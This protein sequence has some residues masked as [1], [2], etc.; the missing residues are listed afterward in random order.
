VVALVVGA[1]I[2]GTVVDV[3]SGGGPTGRP[4]S[5]PSAFKGGRGRDGSSCDEPSWDAMA[6]A[7]TATTVTTGA[8]TATHFLPISGPRSTRFGVQAVQASSTSTRTARRLRSTPV[9]PT[10]RGDQTR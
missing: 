10:E 2:G 8:T 5:A 3:D 6:T 4:D 1:G 7:P 9:M